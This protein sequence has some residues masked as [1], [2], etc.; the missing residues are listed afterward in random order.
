MT[1]QLTEQLP[2][3]QQPPAPTGPVRVP[4]ATVPRVNLLPLEIVQGRRFRRTKQWL[5]V[6]VFAGVVVAAAGTYLAQREVA[7]ERGELTVAQSQVTTLQSQA[8]KYS[9]VP[10]VVAQV[11][12][13]S[14]A[15]A[16]VMGQDVLW[17][18]FM[19]DLEGALPPGVSQD[20]ITV[21]LT[22][23][24]A[25]S[26]GP[27]AASP[28]AAGGVGTLTVTGD[29]EQYQEVSSWLDALAKVHGLSS[30][31]LTNA[32]K[33]QDAGATT[34]TYSISA[35]VTDA[36]FSHRYDKEGS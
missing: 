4:W 36:A 12:A 23:K 32:T 24:T 10:A 22:P 34:V 29:A 35:V 15:R 28:L 19:S 31:A 26:T 8:V 11:D 2:D 33:S 17:Y 21:T 25:A 30:P 27:A 20:A 13:A 18:Q 9:A 7:H 3:E 5:G 1:E 14:S 6:L 16:D